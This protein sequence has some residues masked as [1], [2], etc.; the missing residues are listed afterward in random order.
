MKSSPT[1]NKPPACDCHFHVFNAGEG[2][3]LARYAPDYASSLSA[4]EAPARK[5]GV[6]RGVVVQPSFLGVDNR[7]L[8]ATLRLNP[9]H[10]RGVA[11]VD[12]SATEAE[13]HHLHASGVR[14]V[15]LNLMGVTDDLQAIRNLPAAWWSALIAA[16]LHLELHTDIGRVTTLLPWLPLNATVVLDHFAKAQTA[17]L[18]DE[19]VQAVRR[20]REAGGTTHV[21]LSGAYRLGVSDALQQTK[22]ST[23]LAAVWLDVLGRDFLLWGSDWPCTNHESAARYARLRDLLDHWLPDVN[24]RHAALHTNPQ[25]LYWR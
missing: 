2:I 23:E 9:E 7:M 8:V 11:V 13:L 1:A 12:E 10:L 20:R 6:T 22:F 19:T 18:A 14:G 4:W 21:T 15:R 3:V 5:A 17:S 24:D 25:R 16:E